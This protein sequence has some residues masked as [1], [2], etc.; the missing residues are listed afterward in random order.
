M[1]NLAGFK[2]F[3]LM[4]MPHFGHYT[5][6][7]RVARQLLALIHDGCL[8]IW[9]RIPIDPAL[10]NQI[11]GLLM[12]GSYPMAKVGKKYEAETTAEV[13]QDYVEP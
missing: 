6:T 13:R 11:M 8:W 7:D 4:S 10:I 1:A 2:I 3:N 5:I 9:D 12:T